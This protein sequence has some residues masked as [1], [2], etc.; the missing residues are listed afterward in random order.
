MQYPIGQKVIIRATGAGCHFGTLEAVDGRTVQLTNARRLWRWWS[1]GGE[2]SLSG[3][4]RHGLKE[5]EPSVRI[6]GVVES[7]I[8][9]EVCE[10]L[11]MTDKAIA[12]LEEAEVTNAR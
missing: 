3:I 9:T 1:G 8:I 11:C 7:M 10:I 12:S 2:I 5:N 4:A 6:T